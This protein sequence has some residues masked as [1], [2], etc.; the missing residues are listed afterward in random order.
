[1]HKFS[2]FSEERTFDGD[3]IPIADVLNREIAVLNYRTGGSKQKAGTKC[4]TI[5]IE[6]D[7]KHR[8]I[9]TGSE[10]LAN[11]LEKYSDQ[12]PFMTTIKKINDFYSF[13]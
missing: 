12:L 3:K 11:Q 9:F 5:Q 13:T 8:V 1:M 4:T 7:G 2:G 6:V 10:V